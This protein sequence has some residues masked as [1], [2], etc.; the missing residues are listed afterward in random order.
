MFKMCQNIKNILYCQKDVKCPKVKQLGWEE[1][2][3][4]QLDTVRF[5]HNEVYFDVT[6]EGH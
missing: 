6:C 3:K 5:M 4:K 1:V 2:G